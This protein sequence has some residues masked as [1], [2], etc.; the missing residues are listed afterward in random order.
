MGRV[1]HGVAQKLAVHNNHSPQPWK[2]L[3]Y[4]PMVNL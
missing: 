4:Q 1:N 2:R 3:L